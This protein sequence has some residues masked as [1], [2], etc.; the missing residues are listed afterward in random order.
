[1]NCKNKLLTA[2]TPIYVISAEKTM[3]QLVFI[4]FEPKK[5][6]CELKNVLWVT[7]G[8]TLNWPTQIIFWKLLMIIC[9]R[10]APCI[11]SIGYR[12]V[13]TL[14]VKN[15]ANLA[16]DDQFAKVLYANFSVLP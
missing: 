12:I 9:K 4:A 5:T 13:K 6:T 15:L 8:H 11:T 14:V 2:L 16:I 3:K 7:G 1:M 10:H